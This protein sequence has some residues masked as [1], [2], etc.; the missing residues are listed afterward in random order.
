MVESRTYK[1]AIAVFQKLKT[2]EAVENDFFK[3]ENTKT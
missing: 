2:D 1:M 3:K